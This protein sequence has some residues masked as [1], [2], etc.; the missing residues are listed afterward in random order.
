MQLQRSQ[1]ELPFKSPVIRAKEE[2]TPDITAME[3]N[4]DQ[5]KRNY[6]SDDLLKW[7]KSKNPLPPLNTMRGFGRYRRAECAEPQW[8]FEHLKR[9]IRGIE[10]LPRMTA[11]L[12]MEPMTGLSNEEWQMLTGGVMRRDSTVS[13]MSTATDSS[14]CLF[15]TGTRIARGFSPSGSSTRS[16]QTSHARKGSTLST[17][18]LPADFNSPPLPSSLKRAATLPGERRPSLPLTTIQELQSNVGPVAEVYRKVEKPCEFSIGGDLDS[19]V[20]SDAEDE[21]GWTDVLESNPVKVSAIT[22]MLKEGN[23]HESQ[24]HIQPQLGLTRVRT[25]SSDKRRARGSTVT[26]DRSRTI[27]AARPELKG[28]QSKGRSTHERGKFESTSDSQQSQ[29]APQESLEQSSAGL[30]LHVAGQMKKQTKSQPANT[31]V[32]FDNESKHIDPQKHYAAKRSSPTFFFPEP[33]TGRG[34]QQACLAH[35]AK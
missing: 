33:N 20:A 11:G 16:S 1:S 15:E 5:I 14:T 28:R 25:S 10:H 6:S 17:M 24:P 26:L 23:K 12:D 30:E 8:Y 35:V 22:Q 32:R 31:D 13:S 18:N 3:L 27:R 2:F 19:A 4:P 21:D 9:Q 7:D 34:D 29:Q